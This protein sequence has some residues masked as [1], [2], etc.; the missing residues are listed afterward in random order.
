MPLVALER[1]VSGA[2]MTCT[3]SSELVA[4]EAGRLAVKI[5]RINVKA[6]AIFRMFLPE[7]FG[8]E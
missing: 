4:S 8:M 2:D 6:T 5:V 1:L 7:C 3:L